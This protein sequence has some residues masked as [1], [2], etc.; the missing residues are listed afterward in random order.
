VLEALV[1]QKRLSR[2]ESG[3]YGRAPRQRPKGQGPFGPP[4][5]DV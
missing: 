3:G 2:T 1:A 5:F 4:T